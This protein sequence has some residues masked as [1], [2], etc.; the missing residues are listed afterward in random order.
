MAVILL[1]SVEVGLHLAQSPVV[2][3]APGAEVG[4]DNAGVRGPLHLELG[5][6]ERPPRGHLGAGLVEELEQHRDRLHRRPVH[7]EAGAD[8]DPPRQLAGFGGRKLPTAGEPGHRGRLGER[9]Q[10][11]DHWAF[12]ER[13]AM[14]PTSFLA[15]PR[16][17]SARLRAPRRP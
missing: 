7:L 1:R 5:C 12:P 10:L 15:H 14:G 16:A 3:E 4:A 9:R 8:A 13:R 17:F 6:R 11:D 2:G